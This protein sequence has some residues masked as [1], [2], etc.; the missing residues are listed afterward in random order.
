VPPSLK[1]PDFKWKF[2]FCPFSIG[3]SALE[4]RAKQMPPK[5]LIN[6]RYIAIMKNEIEIFVHT[7]ERPEPRVIKITGDATVENL[8]SV[9]KAT[10]AVIGELEEEILLLVENEEK[11]L[12]REHKLSDCGIKHGHHVH[13]H[14]VVIIVNTREKRWNKK[15]ISYE[16]VVILAFGAYSPDPN[17]VY[18]IKFSKGPEHNREGSLVKG[19]SVKVKCGMI[20]DVTQTNKS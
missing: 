8:A 20:F 16:Q 10:G 4:K 17:T 19:K 2:I 1:N 3:N 14:G 13:W 11:L 15:A 7:G 5:Q 9:I 12:K 18:T 6:K